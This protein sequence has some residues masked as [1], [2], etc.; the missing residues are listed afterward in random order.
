[1]QGRATPEIDEIRGPDS[2]VAVVSR[3]LLCHPQRCCLSNPSSD[4]HLLAP[5]NVAQ[6][7][8]RLPPS[9]WRAI[10]ENIAEELGE[11]SHTETCMA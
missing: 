9:A 4:V 6:C 7:I 1:M 2:I 8:C 11:V 10:A 5:A 3:S